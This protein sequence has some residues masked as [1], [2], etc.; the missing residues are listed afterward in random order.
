MP[1]KVSKENLNILL[2]QDLKGWEF[3]DNYIEKKFVFNDFQS[4]FSFMTFIALKCE[5]MNH[6]PNWSNVYNT[7][8][9]RLQTHSIEDVSNLD[10]DLAYFI[11]SVYQ[12]FFK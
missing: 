1:K 8:I 12:K 4:A 5:Q 3:R 2:Q 11:E 10:M 6:H 7:V 9:I